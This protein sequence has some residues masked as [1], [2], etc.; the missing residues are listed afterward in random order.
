MKHSLQFLSRF[1]FCFFLLILSNSVWA[2]NQ[3]YVS[4]VNINLY[5]RKILKHHKDA[6][7]SI[8]DLHGNAQKLLY[9]L[10]SNNIVQSSGKD[11]KSFSK[12]YK[13][14]PTEIT[15]EDLVRFREIIDSLVINHDNK[16]MFLGDDLS[17]R[18]MN[19]YYTLYIF[20]KLDESK[21]NFK[22]VLSNHGNF[23]IRTYE[24][25]EQ[26]FSINPYGEGQY[27]DVVRSMLNMGKFIERG[28][29]TQQSVI[30]ILER[31]YFKHI[32]LPGVVVD[33]ANS[34]L[35]IYS[36]APID[37]SML[38]SLGKDLHVVFMDDNFSHL[39]HGL[40]GINKK[41]QMWISKKEFTSHYNRLKD[42]HKLLH[43]PSYLEEVI[44]NRDYSILNR[45]YEPENKSYKVNYVHGH[46]SAPNVF[47]LDNEFGKGDDNDI[48][49]Y[50]I[51]VSTPIS[52][53]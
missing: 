44:W 11:Y 18:G 19:D 51:H 5:P 9:F 40:D 53:T 14:S 12:I 20:K 36:H 23:F 2:E 47:D 31:N 42:T 52:S 46:D 33:K 3:H 49:A 1:L 45:D 21:V 37:V 39:V 30:E 25:P 6:T 43:S 7:I 50:A 26:S 28:L 10:I 29:I 24:R 22:V 8:G 48:G 34:E 4:H 16:L 27:E 13:K 38:L 32:V 17:D 35:T 41:I 15:P